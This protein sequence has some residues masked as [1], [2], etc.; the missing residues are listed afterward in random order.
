MNTPNTAFGQLLR[1]ERRR[2]RLTQEQCAGL[3]GISKKT[4]E[5]WESARHPV[6]M[7]TQEGAL[8]RL[9]GIA[10]PFHKEVLTTCE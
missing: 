5:N 8:A 6:L 4:L 2:L 3:L 9:Y 10:E 7:I 1:D